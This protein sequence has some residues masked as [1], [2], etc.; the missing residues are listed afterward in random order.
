MIYYDNSDANL[1][2]SV[3]YDFACHPEKMEPFCTELPSGA[4]IRRMHEDI[5]DALN[6]VTMKTQQSAAPVYASTLDARTFF[7]YLGCNLQPNQIERLANVFRDYFA[8]DPWLYDRESEERQRFEAQMKQIGLLKKP[9]RYLLV[10]PDSV[11]QIKETL[12]ESIGTLLYGLL[13]D[14][15]KFQILRDATNQP[16]FLVKE[17]S[18]E[19]QQS[20]VMIPET[21]LQAY[22]VEKAAKTAK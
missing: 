2:D 7:H 9:E 3:S 15:H 11:L 20:T 12:V 17:V 4:T 10:A 1:I 18:R 14:Y 8:N 5:C 21:W 6:L 19:T 16:Y 22:L 13:S